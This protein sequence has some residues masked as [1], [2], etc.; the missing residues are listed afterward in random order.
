MGHG[1]LAVLLLGVS[2]AAMAQ[3]PPPEL[4]FPLECASSSDCVAVYYPDRKEGPGAQDY[5][6]GNNAVDG[7][8]YAQISIRSLYEMDKGIPVRA[9]ADGTVNVVRDGIHDE[10]PNWRTPKGE[11]PPYCGN[12]IE[13]DHGNGWTGRYC[14]LREASLFV[15]AGDTITAGDTIAFAGWS[16]KAELPGLGFWLRNSATVVDPFDSK[17]VAL[18]CDG[19]GQPLWKDAPPHIDRYND[20]VVVDAGFTASPQ[21][22]VPDVIRGYH[23]QESLPLTSPSLVFWVMV[24]NATAG[25]V[26]TLKLVGP[27]NELVAEQEQAERDDSP[28]VLLHTGSARPKTGWK[29]GEYTA[30]VDIARKVNGQVRRT[31]KSYRVEMK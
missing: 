23:R 2:T 5:M 29:A 10:G 6:C 30:T 7:L 13:I 21:P 3:P 8:P 15:K 24:A 12:A 1:T 31:S 22:L 14:H 16:G 27:D 9:A 11:P 28:V 17:E 4:V 20:V 26:R 25:E 19:D 18:P